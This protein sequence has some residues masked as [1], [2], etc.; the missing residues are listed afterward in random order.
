MKKR[1]ISLVLAVVLVCSMCF[2]ASAA[3][4]YGTTNGTTPKQTRAILNIGTNSASASTW[5]ET[6][7]S[8]ILGTYLEFTYIN[9]INEETFKIG[10]GN[11]S[12]AVQPSDIKPSGAVSAFSNHVV[13]GGST[14]GSWRYSMTVH[15]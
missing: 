9:T 5:C 11:A 12:A 10:T 3:T 13:D 1:I 4:Y 7:G 2:A 8:S 14:I 15:R 6:G